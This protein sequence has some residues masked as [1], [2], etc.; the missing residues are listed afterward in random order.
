MAT[1]VCHLISLYKLY[2]WCS[3]PQ[4]NSLVQ[5]S[6]ALGTDL[7]GRNSAQ[8]CLY[9]GS[10]GPIWYEWWQYGHQF[11]K[12]QWIPC[13]RRGKRT[14]SSQNNMEMDDSVIGKIPQDGYC[15]KSRSPKVNQLVIPIKELS[16]KKWLV[17]LIWI[18]QMEEPVTSFI[19][20]GTNITCIELKGETNKLTKPWIHWANSTNKQ[21][22]SSKYK[23]K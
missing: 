19:A 6:L 3:L 11:Q 14:G 15:G 17:G 2:P 9:H 12:W 1:F 21:V 20:M 13:L 4:S 7:W 23:G 16:R 8:K 18:G 10:L 5:F 22:R